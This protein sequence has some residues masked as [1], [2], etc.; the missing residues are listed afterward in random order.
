MIHYSFDSTTCQAGRLNMTEGS[1]S[2]GL[3]DAPADWDTST[4][5][6]LLGRL[7]QSSPADRTRL[8]HEVSINV[9][10]GFA[11]ALARLIEPHRTELDKSKQGLPEAVDLAYLLRRRLERVR[12]V[13]LENSAHG[14]LMA[15]LDEWLN[16]F[17]SI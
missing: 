5:S 16:E 10:K 14:R 17:D 7:I 15:A 6:R 1:W 12:C 3:I 4:A 2:P 9:G 11:D 8:Y 13:W